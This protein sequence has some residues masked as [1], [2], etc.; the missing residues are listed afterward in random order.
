MNIIVNSAH[1]FAVSCDSLYNAWLKVD[2]PYEFYEV[3]LSIYSGETGDK[4]DRKKIASLIKEMQLGFNIKLGELKWG[5][6]NRAFKANKENNEILPSLMTVKFMNPKTAE[7]LY[8]LYTDND[9]KDFAELYMLMSANPDIDKR[10]IKN[11]II[12]N[13]F[14][15]FGNR[16]KLLDFITLVDEKFSK[17]TYNKTADP[18]IVNVVKPFAKSGHESNKKTYRDIDFKA[19]YSFIFSTLS[20]DDLDIKELYKLEYEL[21]GNIISEIPNGMAIGIVSAK[22]YKKPWMLFESLR[23]GNQI[24]LQ[25]RIPAP[26]IPKKGSLVVLENITSQRGYGGRI[27]YS[28]DIET[29]IDG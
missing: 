7:A 17:K 18:S 21:T 2:Y 29:L 27:T 24:W 1:A 8:K 23:N 11:L 14:S 25:T 16:K 5:N 3:C 13:Y 6:D 19:L 15:E 26:K 4:K 20:N 22:S 10:A 28:A 9:I 12:I